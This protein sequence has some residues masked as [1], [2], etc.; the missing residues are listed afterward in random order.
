[1]QKQNTSKNRTKQTK[2][3]SVN[4]DSDTEKQDGGRD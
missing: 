2:L 3:F 4:F 1:M